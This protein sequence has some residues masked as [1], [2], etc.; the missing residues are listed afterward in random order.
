M[1]FDVYDEDNDP[2]RYLLTTTEYFAYHFRVSEYVDEIYSHL[3]ETENRN[4]IH[5]NFLQAQPEIDADMRM[6]LFDWYEFFIL[7]SI[8]V[9]K[10]R[11]VGT[12]FNWSSE[13]L[14]LSLNLVDRYTEKVLISKT[15]YQLGITLIAIILFKL[16]LRIS[17]Y[18]GFAFGL[19]IRR[20]N[21]RN[22]ND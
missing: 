2:Q 16:D 7:G 12:N 8:F 17:W 14:F 22:C 15:N 13:T 21:A 20:F 4:M 1:D 5:K 10:F 18:G 11:L 19:Q 6:I 3:F 9:I